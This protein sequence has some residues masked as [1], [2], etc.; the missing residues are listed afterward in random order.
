MTVRDVDDRRVRFRALH[1]AG[2]GFILPNP[3]DLGSA[4]LLEAMEFQAVLRH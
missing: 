3:F 1:E 2:E 4:H